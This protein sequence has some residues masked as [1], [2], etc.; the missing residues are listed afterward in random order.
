VRLDPVTTGETPGCDG[1]S[2]TPNVAMAAM[3]VT[4]QFKG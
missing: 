1:Q 2:A 3:T 4:R